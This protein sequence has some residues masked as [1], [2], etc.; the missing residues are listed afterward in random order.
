[1]PPLPPSPQNL[2]PRQLPPPTRESRIRSSHLV[3]PFCASFLNL[4]NSNISPTTLPS[5]LNV[6]QFPSLA[7]SSHSSPRTVHFILGQKK[8]SEAV[9]NASVLAFQAM[10][11]AAI[12]NNQFFCVHGGLS[13]ELQTI[14][15]LQKVHPC[16]A[17]L[18]SFEP[19]Y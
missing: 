7:L 3:H 13:P 15:D 18:P 9:Y 1:M 11:L 19:R 6:R 16:P 14:D 10:P 2:P 17:H 5:G 8:Y 12:V 4:V